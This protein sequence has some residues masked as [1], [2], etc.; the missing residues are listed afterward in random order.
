[1]TTEEREA[2]KQEEFS[3][4]PL[5]ILK[6]SVRNNTQVLIKCRNNKE[7]LGRVKAFDRHC[8]MVLEGVKEIWITALRT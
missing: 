1:M 4:G 7:L 5:S 3:I 2:R 6:D 8:N